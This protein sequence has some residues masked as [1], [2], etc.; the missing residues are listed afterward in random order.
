MT[1]MGAVAGD[2]YFHWPVPETNRRR[3]HRSSCGM[4]GRRLSCF[5]QDSAIIV[6]QKYKAWIKEARRA[7]RDFV[8]SLELKRRRENE[9]S[10]QR[11]Y[12]DALNNFKCLMKEIEAFFMFI[13][14]LNTG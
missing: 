6:S 1:A 2:M 9:N 12:H 4:I 5:S 13:P 10:E 7:F 14:F 8:H 3:Y 11:S